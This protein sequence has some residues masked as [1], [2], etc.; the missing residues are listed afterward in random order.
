M[1]QLFTILLILCSSALFAQT[2]DTLAI[3]ASVSD[4]NNFPVTVRWSQVSGPTAVISSVNTANTVI[5]AIKEG[6]SIFRLTATN[7]YGAVAYK[8]FTVI[9][10]A[11]QAP[12]IIADK[13]RFNI[14]LPAK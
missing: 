10:V 6:T 4:P 11:N 8:E 3:K 14:T 1:K 13:D 12:V 2:T 9:A 5:R 7:S